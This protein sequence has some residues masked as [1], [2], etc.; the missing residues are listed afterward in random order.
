MNCEEVMELMQRHVDHDLDEQE[1]SLLMDHVGHC[2]DCAA[3]LEKLVNLSRGLEQLP[4]VVPPYSLVD[5]ILPELGDWDAAAAET[6]GEASLAP[7]SRRASRPRRS[8]IAKLSGVVA[9]G[10]AV[11]VLLVNGPFTGRLGSSQQDAASAP[12]AAANQESASTSDKSF[13]MKLTTKDQY[14]EAQ[15]PPAGSSSTFLAPDTTTRNFS[16]KELSKEGAASQE[17][18][19]GGGGASGSYGASNAAPSGSPAANAGTGG[20]HG[21]NADQYFAATPS[22]SP[23]EPPV[24]D[25]G[26]TLTAAK[27]E[28]LSP[29]GKWKAVLTDGVLQVFNASDGSLAFGPT[30]EGGKRSGLVWNESSTELDYTFTDP[31]GKQTPMYLKV[32]EMKEASR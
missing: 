26:V 23:A 16:S 24:S 30:P 21:E 5:K 31:E 13:S 14:G 4:R 32:P 15:E 1:T 7:R 18:S 22:D 19:S 20:T 28:S 27:E 3:M 12:E 17:P 8:W 11:G 2:P 6:G 10:I 25:K 29:D 9:L